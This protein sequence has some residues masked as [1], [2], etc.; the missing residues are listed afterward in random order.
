MNRKIQYYKNYFID[1]YSSLDVA[2]QRKIYQDGTTM[3][4]EIRE[5]H[6]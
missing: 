3:E 6:P 4:R 2:A 1:F 5:I